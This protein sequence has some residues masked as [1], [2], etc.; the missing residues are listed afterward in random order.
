MQRSLLLVVVSALFLVGPPVQAQ[1][2]TDVVA[3]YFGALQAGDY[4]KTASYFDPQAL[5]TFRE[6]MGFMTDLPVEAKEQFFTM[7]FGPGTTEEAIAALSDSGFFAKFFGAVMTQAEAAGGINFGA[8]EVLGQVMEGSDV[9]HVV[10]RN[11]VSVGQ[12]EVEA[13]EVVSAK[14]TAGVWRLLL[15]AEMKGLADQLRAGFLG[16]P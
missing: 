12:I 13:M 11:R 10:T 1:E 7:F 9:A 15:S 16:Q 6:T 2:A 8:M 3:S 4:D 5:K 14:Q